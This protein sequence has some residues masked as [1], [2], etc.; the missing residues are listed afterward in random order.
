MDQ[1]ICVTCGATIENKTKRRNPRQFCNSSCRNKHWHAVSIGRETVEVKPVKLAGP[2]MSNWE[3]IMS[4][5]DPV[6]HR[7]TNAPM[8]EVTK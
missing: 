5:V 7:Y 3:R 4:R 8:V 6:T 1:V 2:K